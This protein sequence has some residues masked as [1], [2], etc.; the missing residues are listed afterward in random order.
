MEVNRTIDINVGDGNET[1]KFDN[2]VEGGNQTFDADIQKLNET[3]TVSSPSNQT[4]EKVEQEIQQNIHKMGE[5]FIISSQPKA[6]STEPSSTEP[7]EIMTPE[8]S[9]SSIIEVEKVLSPSSQ[10]FIPSQEV[11][12]LQDLTP[13][14]VESEKIA[15]VQEFSPS[16]DQ[17]VSITEMMDISIAETKE[18]ETSV[19]EN[20]PITVSL[21]HL[22]PL[23]QI[24]QPEAQELP[25]IS[26]KPEVIATEEKNISP[27]EIVTPDEVGVPQSELEVSYH[28][29][30]EISFEKLPVKENLEAEKPQQS[31]PTVTAEAI[32]SPS[33]SKKAENVFVEK[34]ESSIEVQFK[35]PAAPVFKQSDV[36]SDEEFKTCGS[37]CK[38][39]SMKSICVRSE[40]HSLTH[41]NR[42]E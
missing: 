10:E 7:K 23:Q 41:N 26:S 29:I 39:L 22:S 36:P 30:D 42:F 25:D 14:I 21:E 38:N 3:K 16:Q 12:P 4:I 17:N 13:S 18:V 9:R 28:N 27:T 2:T 5:S 15:S 8:V 40:M 6:S 34:M 11:S 32:K 1:L 19:K 35:M 31:S 37:S 33:P 24:E 20:L